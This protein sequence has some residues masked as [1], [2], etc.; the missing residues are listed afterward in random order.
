MGNNYEPQAF[1]EALKSKTR[2]GVIPS[3][4]YCGGTNFTTIQDYAA[5]PVQHDFGGVVLGQTVPLGM[6]ICTKCGHVDFFALGALGI[7]PK[8]EDD[9]NGD[10]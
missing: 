2:N 9:G 7:L 4:P 5:V 6:V 3:C 1:I 10:R 8:K